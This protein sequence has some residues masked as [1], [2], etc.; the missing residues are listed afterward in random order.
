[1]AIPLY[2]NKIASPSARND[3]VAKG[4]KDTYEIASSLESQK[5]LVLKSLFVIMTPQLKR[6]QAFG[7]L[8]A[9]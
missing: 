6:P 7:V 3:V 8:R 5:R 2:R 1:M 9:A 4:L